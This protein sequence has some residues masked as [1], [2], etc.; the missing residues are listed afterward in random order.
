MVQWVDGWCGSM[1]VALH[2]NEHR[3]NATETSEPIVL[4]DQL[5]REMAR[6]SLELIFDHKNPVS[7]ATPVKAVAR[8]GGHNYAAQDQASIVRT[9]GDHSP[10]PRPCK[11]SDSELNLSRVRDKSRSGEARTLSAQRSKSSG[12]G[13]H[14]RLSDS[15]EQEQITQ[16]LQESFGPD[17]RPLERTA[18]NRHTQPLS[19]LDAI[20]DLS[21]LDGLAALKRK[22]GAHSDELESNDDG[23]VLAFEQAMFPKETIGQVLRSQLKTHRGSEDSTLDHK[24]AFHASSSS[25]SSLAERLVKGRSRVG[26]KRNSSPIPTGTHSLDED[27]SD[28]DGLATSSATQANTTN[29]TTIS[30]NNSSVNSAA[31]RL[32]SAL[33][34]RTLGRKLP[35]PAVTNGGFISEP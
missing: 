18:S 12:S 4:V 25:S 31:T 27:A 33:A 30:S 11:T 2:S 21:A 5:R 23:R 19:I 35:D 26:R 6:M 17:L 28:L 22:Q 10:S 9:N 16:I 24:S 15:E 14:E 32:A 20:D 3:T 29:N 34:A 7:P 1:E 8:R 13:D